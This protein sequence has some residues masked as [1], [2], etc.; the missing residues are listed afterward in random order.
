MSSLLKQLG[1]D[2]AILMMYVAGEL[3][4][5]DIAE[6]DRR[7]AAD[8]G[9]RRDLDRLRDADHRFTSAMRALD[10]A[11]RPAVPESS[12]VR[13]VK[14]MIRQWHADRLARQA[15]AVPV[16]DMR[17]PWW[18]YPLAAAASIVVAFM[19]WWGN[20]DRTDDRLAARNVPLHFDKIG[21]A[22]V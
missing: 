11:S 3:P 1:D 13:R 5:A 8:V 17:F 7:L 18:A 10:G 22:H 19:V 16:P 20:A 15:P 21:R 2:E 4:P 6:V 9:L 12:G 14:R